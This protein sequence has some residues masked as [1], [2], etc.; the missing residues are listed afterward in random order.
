MNRKISYKQITIIGLGLMGG[1]FAKALSVQTSARI[2]AVDQSQE[3]INYAKQKK[4]I[5][6]GFTTISDS[7][8]VTDLIVL[9]TPVSTLPN[10]LQAID[11][12]YENEPQI[13]DISSVKANVI[14]Y[15]NH[16]DLKNRF[17]SCHPMV[18]SEKGGIITSDQLNFENKT[19][20]LLEEYYCKK[21]DDLLK[22]LGFECIIIKAQNHDKYLAVSSH[23]PY[24]MACLTSRLLE[25]QGYEHEINQA[26]VGSGFLDTTRI[27]QSEIHWGLDVCLENK[28][29]LKEL[30]NML[31][32]E[33]TNL[34]DAI[35]S[36]EKLKTLLS[37][38][39]AFRS[40]L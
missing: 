5:Y 31:K 23:F 13:L 6:D 27:S 36:S 17:I 15:I 7:P 8:K 32:E 16:S 28:N 29:S 10:I 39:K 33:I 20:L 19:C 22:K 2:V 35:E 30:L 21:I 1:A 25:R 14:N 18:G 40:N 37:T 38:I 26:I 11:G 12:H 24:L 34:E 4:W 3:S 9:A